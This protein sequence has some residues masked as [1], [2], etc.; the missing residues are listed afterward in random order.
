MLNAH[1]QSRRLNPEAFARARSE[2][3]GLLPLLDD[4]KN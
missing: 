3:R 2:Q 4:F 1:H